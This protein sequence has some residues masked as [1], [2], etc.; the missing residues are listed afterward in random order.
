MRGK[1]VKLLVTLLVVSAHTLV[2][3]LD[4][5]GSG[6]DTLL[7]LEDGDTDEGLGEGS[8]GWDINF[9]DSPFNTKDPN[10]SPFNTQ[11][12]YNDK[13]ETSTE[14]T[15]YY[16]DNYDYLEA[17]I[18]KDGDYKAEEN[19]VDY[20]DKEESLLEQDIEIAARPTDTEEEQIV[21][22]TSQIFIMVGS[23]FVSFA[24]FMITFFLCRR[25]ISNKQRKA[26]AYANSP[27]KPPL[28]EPPIVKDYQ[29]VPTS[30]QDILKSSSA[31]PR[32]NMYGEKDPENPSA[33]SLVP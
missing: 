30:A 24:I 16:Y 21:L 14:D 5:E 10:N 1:P 27:E 7:D 18:N 13:K 32:V 8:G 29:K 25:I 6:D 15:D 19:L 28:K 26:M 31:S 20:L 17:Y 2:F 11:D 23:S 9:G 33:A 3:A 12:P 4:L 22:N